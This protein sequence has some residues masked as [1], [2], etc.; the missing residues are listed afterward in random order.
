VVVM[1]V[2]VMVV[3]EM[4]VVVEVNKQCFNKGY[5]LNKIKKI[6]SPNIFQKSWMIP[7]WYDDDKNMVGKNYGSQP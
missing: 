5:N 3:V 2:V 7:S 4:V 6:I 1:V